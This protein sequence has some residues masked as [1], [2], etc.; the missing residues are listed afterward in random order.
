MRSGTLIIGK[1]GQV[2][3]A[4]ARLAPHAMVWS[5]EQADLHNPLALRNALEALPQ[6]PSAIINVAAYTAVDKAE[7]EPDVARAVNADSPAVMAEYAAKHSIPFIHYSTDYVFDGTGDA[8]RTE[9]APTAPLNVYGETKLE[10]EALIQEIG[11]H[12]LILRTSWV[13]DAMG[14]NFFNTMLR[15]GAE[16]E[17][18]KVVADQIGAPSYAPHLA[19]YTLRALKSA[20]KKDSFPSG[21]YHFCH[22]GSVSWHGFA[23]AIFAAARASGMNLKVQSVLPIGTAD[24]PTPAKRPHNSRLDCSKL[25]GTL[26]IRLPSWQEG[27][28]ACMEE[29]HENHRRTA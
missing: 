14:K 25:A 5:R 1:S 8:P 26:G 29:K 17:E 27:L 28:A 3:S 6:S 9:D 7:S 2:G 15:L 22:G 13:Y 20:L 10:G 11:G 23:E 4:L 12:Y 18:L 16:R 24:Y 19:E 21:I